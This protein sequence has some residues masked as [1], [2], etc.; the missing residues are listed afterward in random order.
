M[1]NARVRQLVVMLMLLTCSTT[2]CSCS[3]SSKSVTQPTTTTTTA[4]PPPFPAH[5]R[6]NTSRLVV[7][8]VWLNSYARNVAQGQTSSDVFANAAAHLP[9]IASMGVTAV[10]LSPIHPFGDDTTVGATY[11]IRD[12]YAVNPGYSGVPGGTE[13]A[14]RLG[15]AALKRYIDRAHALGLRVLMD[16]VYHSTETDNVLVAQHPEFYAR[17]RRGR[18]MKNQ[19][20]FAKLDLAKR[21]VRAY[22]IAVTKYWA[23]IGFDGCRGD[24]AT[25]IPVSFWAQLNNE[26]KKVRPD[27][28]MIGEVP[29]RLDQYAG[30]YSGPGW[31]PGERYRGIYAFDAIYGVQYMT[32]LRAIVDGHAPATTLHLAW[33]APDRPAAP[34]PKGTVIYR[35]VDNHDQNPRAAALAG[36]NAGMVAAMAV[37]VT[38][39]GIPYVF[40]GQEIGDIDRTSLYSQTFIDWS[41][42]RHPENAETFRRLIALARTRP[43]LARGTTTWCTVTEPSRAVAFERIG[44][45]DRVIVVAN[46]SSR[47]WKGTVTLPPGTRATSA[48]DLL[49][50]SAHGVAGRR[51]SL[52]LAPYAYVVAALQ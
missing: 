44:S 42:P 18:I 51:L 41:H 11:S 40:N 43:A 22:L 2:S 15:V 23:T 52:S 14:R 5:E 33:S 4:P 38:I 12:Y 46:L 1:K 7:Y 36:G 27:W 35:G 26:M 34:A 20:G 28:L 49:D 39:G 3:S 48:V 25:A 24:L 9:D 10:Q 17:D 8:E 45:G 30:P 19:F 29:Y 50:G 47:P 31:L 37:S 6:I 32:A 13:Q 21:A 16:C